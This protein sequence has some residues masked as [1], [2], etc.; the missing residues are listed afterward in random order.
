MF[1]NPKTQYEKGFNAGFQAHEQYVA[2]G[3]IKRFFGT[4]CLNL[5]GNHPPM[6]MD[7]NFGITAAIAEMLIQSH[8]NGIALLPA[9]PSVW[10]EGSVKSLRARGGF[11]VAMTWKNGNL[12]EATISSKLGGSTKV[13]YNGSSIQMTLAPGASKTVTASDFQK[14]NK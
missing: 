3:Q 2:E 6:Q 1:R 5:F 11:E 4:T 9:L 7:G 10:T 13:S 14:A 12:T 8:E